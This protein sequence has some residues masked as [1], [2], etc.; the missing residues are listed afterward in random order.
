MQDASRWQTRI[1]DLF[2]IRVPILAGGLMWLSDARYVAAVVRAG[3]MAFMTARSFTP[4]ER[5]V[6]E[7][8][9]CADLAQ[10][11]PFG[12]NLSLS[13]R[14]GAN[15]DVRRQLEA[16]V[17]AG[18]R[19]FETV[20]P[21]PATLMRA[22]HDA[23]GVAIHK[24]ARVEHALKAEDAGADAIAL[25][26]MEAAGHPGTNPLPASVLC[27]IALERLRCPLAMG[28]GIG[29]SRQVAAALALGCEAV[30]IGTRLLACD[31]VGIHRGYRERLIASGGEDSVVVLRSTGNPWRVL[32]NA[33]ARE[34][35]R[36][37]GQGASRYEDFGEL[38]L[39][40]YGRDGA[41]V[42]GD[43]ERGL[44]S[45]GPS[46]AFV[47]RAE[48]VATVIE[49]LTAGVATRLRR[50][51]QSAPQDAPGSGAPSR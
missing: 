44:L 32:D 30:V 48:S 9:R 15:D 5:F 18:V 47:D 39:G 2:G 45:M 25:V 11:R 13:N 49:R 3:A 8:A 17:R 51:S 42:G 10:G 31:E 40:T 1:T 19:F 36:L 35:G 21:A 43:P 16:A 24:C 41:Y 33:T 6:E 50:A 23:G 37:E 29:T 26:G 22:I 14:P 46:I 28:G 12:V 38:A 34:V 20:G 4:V 27:S 7:L